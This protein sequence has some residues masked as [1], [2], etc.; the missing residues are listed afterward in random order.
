[1]NI[2]A[3]SFGSA[4]HFLPTLAVASALHGRGHRVRFVANPVFEAQ[5]CRSSLPFVPAGAFRDITAALEANPKYLHSLSGGRAVWNDFVAPNV[6]ATYATVREAISSLRPD[7][8]L[9]N[10]VSF[11]GVW[12]AAEHRVCYALVSSVLPE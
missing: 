8:V 11:G 6:L 1:M 4:G 2:L 12:A 10:N 5:V 3:T 7:V 9:C